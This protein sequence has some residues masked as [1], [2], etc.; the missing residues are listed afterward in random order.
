MVINCLDA[1]NR[2]YSKN[3]KKA[4]FELIT[5][6]AIPII[7]PNF[8]LMNT[9]EILNLRTYAKDELEEM[10]HYVDLLSSEYSPDDTKLEN[11]EIFIKNKITPSIK[12]LEKMVYGLRVGTI[13]KALQNL[14]NPLSYTP[15]LTKFFT[16]IPSYI[17]LS[18]SMGLI[19]A[20]TV[21][22]Y[23]KQKKEIS[24]NPLYFSVKLRR[25]IKNKKTNITSP[26]KR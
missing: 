10:R 2:K 18:V 14:K 9:E 12:Q 7:L 25:K 11:P 8:Y 17:S 19:A 1:I 3:T 16:D 26:N 6:K 15:L 22:E 20:E 21:M 13:Q 4:S 24:T 23:I 5:R